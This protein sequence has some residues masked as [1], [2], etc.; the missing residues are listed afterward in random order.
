MFK[1]EERATIAHCSPHLCRASGK[2]W[3][4]Q[5]RPCPAAFNINRHSVYFRFIRPNLIFLRQK[6]QLGIENPT[7]QV[8]F[9]NKISLRCAEECAAC[10]CKVLTRESVATVPEKC[11]SYSRGSHLQ[12]DIYVT[13]VLSIVLRLSQQPRAVWEDGLVKRR[14]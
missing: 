11:Y 12:A 5:Q 3:H 7:A 9:T 6:W 8:L 14:G 1:P 10:D 4:H 13:N 2:K